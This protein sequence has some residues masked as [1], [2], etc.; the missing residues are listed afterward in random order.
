MRARES[1]GSKGRETDDR[2]VGWQV[3]AG[4]EM[5]SDTG[6]GHS[7]SNPNELSKQDARHREQRLGQVLF[8]KWLTAS[9]QPDSIRKQSTTTHPSSKR[10][11]T[12][13][14]GVRHP[15]RPRPRRTSTPGAIPPTRRQRRRKR[16]GEEAEPSTKSIFSLLF[17]LIWHRGNL[18]S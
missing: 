12:V 17:T 11:T 13:G 18:L 16:E 1:G 7:G 5:T 8:S 10:C 3:E 9:L 4:H 2:K 6:A 15:E 14:R